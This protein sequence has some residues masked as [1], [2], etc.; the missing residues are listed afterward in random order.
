VRLALRRLAPLGLAVSVATWMLVM[1]AV[2]A[3]AATLTVNTTSDTSPLGDGICSLREAITATNAAPFTSDCGAT[4]A[5]GNTIVLPASGFSYSLTAPVSVGDDNGGGDLNVTGSAPLVIQG[6]GA[7]QTTI[8]AS[9]L[10]DRA[11][12]V[13]AGATVTITGLT[14]TGGRAPDGLPGLSA[15]MPPAGNNASTAGNPGK[16]GG[17]IV[18]EGT[19]TLTDDVLTL[20]RAGDGGDGGS[21]SG[22]SPPSAGG[23]G[24]A[25]GAVSS[26]GRLTV[27]R[28]TFGDNHAG[29]GGQGGVGVAGGSPIAGA[30]AGAGGAGG[31]IENSGGDLTVR[32]SLFAQ[33]S[34]GDGGPGGLGGDNS[35]TGEAPSSGG[36]GGD[37]GSGGAIGAVG[38]NTALQ[39]STLVHNSGGAG[40]AGGPAG[41]DESGN[42]PIPGADGSD[43][44]NGSSGGAIFLGGGSVILRGSDNNTLDS[45]TVTDDRSGA[46]GAAG[47]GNRTPGQ[48]GAAPGAGGVVAKSPFSVTLTNTLL[49]QNTNG[50]CGGGVRGDAGDLSFGD[51]T[52]PGPFL[53][54]DPRLD[55]PED[56]GGPTQTVALGTGSAAID[57]GTTCQ[58]SDQRGVA[59]PAATACD[60]GAYEVSAPTAAVSA[61]EGI[62]TT[63]ATLHGAVNPNQI[64]AT[65]HFEYGTTVAYG[66]ST[67]PQTV[68]GVGQQSLSPAPITGLQP[69]TTYHFRLVATS[70]DGTTSTADATFS[71]NAAPSA[72]VSPAGPGQHKSAPP[73]LSRLTIN[74]GKLAHRG[75]HHVTIT[76]LDSAASH[77]TIVLLRRTSGVRQG[78]RCAT[79]VRGST[80]RRCI[81]LVR[82]G[83]LTHV[84]RAGRNRLRLTTRLGRVS[85]PAGKYVLKLTPRLGG[86]TGRTRTLLLRVV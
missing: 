24:G 28:T 21:G 67:T 47:F 71:T 15:N 65:A 20:N 23:A 38:G 61:P 46:P 6:A 1:L 84:D 10:N 55:A 3:G 64:V 52:C 69:G 49:S 26:D 83:S 14:I 60:I 17:A 57:A 76:Y 19:L 25:G 36:R 48:A 59:R 63:A 70:P 73:V 77:T 5:A 44:G 80:R 22:G 45:V 62:S 8:D 51:S 53:S 32:T 16:D 78:K 54:G 12:H 29:A 30:R 82:V 85:L 35:V 81:R 74:P 37:S 56:N 79:A 33:N 18:N 75:H 11:L 13:S 34:A 40:G 2:P 50:N 86:Q 4:D 31:A 58:A 72:G 9:G 43:G 7:G 42:N 41:D 68:N 39:N 27:E 66:Q